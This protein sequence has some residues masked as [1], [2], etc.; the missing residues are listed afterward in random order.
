MRASF[1]RLCFLAR[2]QSLTKILMRIVAYFVLTLFSLVGT[3]FVWDGFA[4]GKLFY[5]SDSCGPIDFI[6]P[7]V[8]SGCGDYYI[9]PACVVWA[10]WAGL[11]AVGLGL[12]AVVVGVTTREDLTR[13]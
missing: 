12:P 1:R 10:L 3:S 13:M 6:P 11:L 5:C 7:F 8:H 9:A 2:V 4:V